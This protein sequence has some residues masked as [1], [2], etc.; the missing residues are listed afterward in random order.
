M[1]IML[2]VA[3]ALVAALTIACESEES[4]VEPVEESAV[5]PVEETEDDDD[6]LARYLIIP[7]SKVLAESG[8]AH[9]GGSISAP[10][11]AQLA[12]SS[13]ALWIPPQ[14]CWHDPDAPLSDPDCLELTEDEVAAMTD[15]KAE[16]EEWF[17][18]AFIVLDHMHGAD[19][20]GTAIERYAML[21]DFLLDIELTYMDV[22]DDIRA[23]VAS[24]SDG[25]IY[26]WC[27]LMRQVASDEVPPGGLGNLPDEV[28]G[29]A[30]A[31]EQWFADDDTSLRNSRR[32]NRYC[33]DRLT[34]RR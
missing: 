3:L 34:E 11:P 14:M 27:D 10:P 1:K 24:A 17:R 29:V 25:D 18:A 13:V 15:P 16:I 30:F 19:R 8:Y 7:P 5:E 22:G 28:R 33:E 26:A 4:A 6:T 21:H 20:P 31:V 12:P 9:F 2:T 23:Y 32:V